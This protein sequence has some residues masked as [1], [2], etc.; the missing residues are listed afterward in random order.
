MGAFAFILQ[1]SGLYHVRILLGLETPRRSVGG[2]RPVYRGNNEE[3]ERQFKG[4]LGAYFD[5]K[6]PRGKE[7][8]R[9]AARSFARRPSVLLFPPLLRLPLLPPPPLSPP[10]LTPPPLPPPPQHPALLL[11]PLP[12]E[13]RR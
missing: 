13:P 5:D 3:G 1:M 4:L 10:P 8:S 6:A 11:P 12:R 7:R 9:N 2:C